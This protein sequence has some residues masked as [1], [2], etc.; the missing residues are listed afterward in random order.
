MSRAAAAADRRRSLG[1]CTDIITEHG[2]GALTM[3]EM[4]RRMGMRAPSLYKYFPSLHA[5]F[6]ALFKR[7]L[8]ARASSDAGC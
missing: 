2:V 1:P 7:G 8:Q 6:D 4:A 3:S 5:A